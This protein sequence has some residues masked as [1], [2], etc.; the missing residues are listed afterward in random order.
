[1]FAVARFQLVRILLILSGIVFC[2][3][4]F[5]FSTTSV[6]LNM[7]AS[8]HILML[9]L[10]KISRDSNNVNNSSEKVENFPPGIKE[11]P[12]RGSGRN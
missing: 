10:V 7:F 6:T 1:M 5:V 9:I 12:L 4:K 11:I 3:S 8:G 2:R